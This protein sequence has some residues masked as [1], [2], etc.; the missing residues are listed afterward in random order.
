MTRVLLLAL[1]ISLAS[2]PALAIPVTVTNVGGQGQ[3][4]LFRASLG[5]LALT[6][7]GSVTISDS[8]SGIGGSA[9]VFSGFDLDFVFLDLDGN[10]ATTDDR[11]F[12]SIFVFTTGA[13]RP[14]ADPAFQPTVSR[15]GPTFGSS[16]ADTIDHDLSTLNVRDATF[17]SA[18]TTS[19]SFGWLTLGDGGSLSIGFASPIPLAG[20]EALFFGEVGLGTGE[21]IN[22]TVEVSERVIPEP[23]TLGLVGLSLIGFGAGRRRMR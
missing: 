13:I 9:G 11:V 14:T 12:G 7:L 15:P 8:N 5:G 10:L 20:T 1:W 3:T 6:E 21:Q 23:G 16:A 19:N 2:S 22:A 18:F 17:P 4:T